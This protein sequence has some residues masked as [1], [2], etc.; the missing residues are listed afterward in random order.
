MMMFGVF[1]APKLNEQHAHHAAISTQ[2][3][4]FIFIGPE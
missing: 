4:E 3:F 1:G 2:S